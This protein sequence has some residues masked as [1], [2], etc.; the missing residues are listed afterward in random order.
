MKFHL[1]LNN[2]V[3]L[4][5]L[6]ISLRLRISLVEEGGLI[7]SSDNPLDFHVKIWPL[8]LLTVIKYLYFA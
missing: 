1:V 6:R 2:F 5:L 3:V 7:L 4:L 8:V